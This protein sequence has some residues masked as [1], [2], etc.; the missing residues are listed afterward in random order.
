VNRHALQSL[1]RKVLEICGLNEVLTHIGIAK[2]WC[3]GAQNLE[4]K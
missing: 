3:K 4:T 1:G 2:I